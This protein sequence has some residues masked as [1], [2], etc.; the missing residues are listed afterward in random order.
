MAAPPPAP[1]ANIQAFSLP[2][3]TAHPSLQSMASTSAVA[4]SSASVA[5]APKPRRR[6]P[7][8]AKK[9][10]EDWIEGHKGT[11][12]A[13][14]PSLPERRDLLAQIH[15]V[16]GTEW[17]QLQTVDRFFTS[18]RK[19]A[20]SEPKRKGRKPRLSET[21]TKPS[22]NWPSLSPD[23]L[24]RLPKLLAS[25]PNPDNKAIGTWLLALPGFPTADD[26][27]K[28]I[29]YKKSTA[30]LCREEN[31][32]YED[33]DSH[34][35]HLPTPEATASPEPVYRNLP[36]P[37]ESIKG[38]PVSPILPQNGTWTLSRVSKVGDPVAYKWKTTSTQASY[39]T[40]Q[41][42]Q[43]K[44]FHATAGPSHGLFSAPPQ[45]GPSMNGGVTTAAL[46]KELA[47]SVKD[48]LSEPEAELNDA[49]RVTPAEFVRRFEPHE[50][51]LEEF[52]VKAQRGEY[53]ALGLVPSMVPK[54]TYVKPEGYEPMDED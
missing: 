2:P 52:L 27:R 38:S 23:A 29:Q 1:P 48:A 54:D 25:D 47:L 13:L 46:L 17:Y 20:N 28:W 30:E 50:Q 39:V 5:P 40:T 33:E 16:K 18:R 9:I 37:A 53:A 24:E 19:S 8:E 3:F 36:S 44:P 34:V 31:S 6:L 14:R 41:P 21:E 26:I 32:D 22:S 7:P 12:N 35:Q 45:A 11:E 4:S 42:P 15:R 43:L 49:E 51:R 10:L